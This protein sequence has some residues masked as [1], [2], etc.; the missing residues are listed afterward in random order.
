ECGQDQPEDD[1]LQLADV[2]LSTATWSMP[3]GFEESFIYVE[4]NE[5]AEVATNW[6]A[7]PTEPELPLLNVLNVVLYTGLDWG[8]LADSCGRVPLEAVKEQLAGYRE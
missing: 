4:D 6:Y 5:V 7:V 8:D 2:D 3:D 1:E